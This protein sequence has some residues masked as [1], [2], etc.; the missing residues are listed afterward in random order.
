[1]YQISLNLLTAAQQENIINRVPLLRELQQLDEQ[2]YQQVLAACSIVKS[3]S[4]QVVLAKGSQAKG[5]CFL[6]S[7][8]LSVYSNEVAGQPINNIFAG[9]MFGDLAMLDNALRRVTVAVAS[10]VT[11]ASFLQIDIAAFGDLNDFSRFN[12]MT[13]VKFYQ[14]IVMAIRW[15]IELKRSQTPQHPLVDVLKKVAM[16][17]GEKDTVAHLHALHLQARQLSCLLTGWDG[18]SF[19][20]EEVLESIAAAS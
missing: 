11:K 17:R 12:L 5:L 6:L 16:F 15:R 1:M 20:D 2:Q 14:A 3:E 8:E 13:K 10:T 18:N 19:C 9:E 4:G 7:G